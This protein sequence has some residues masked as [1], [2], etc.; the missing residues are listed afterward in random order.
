MGTSLP[1]IPPKPKASIQI[2]KQPQQAFPP[3]NQQASPPQNQ[4][5]EKILRWLLPNEHCIPTL[6]NHFLTVVLKLCSA[7]VKGFLVQQ[8][9]LIGYV[10]STEY[11]SVVTP[12]NQIFPWESLVRALELLIPMVPQIVFFLR[13][14]RLSDL[15]LPIEMDYS[16]VQFL[17]KFGVWT[18]VDRLQGFLTQYISEATSFGFGKPIASEVLHFILSNSDLSNQKEPINRFH[19]LQTLSL[20]THLLINTEVCA[21]LCQ[22]DS[23]HFLLPRLIADSASFEMS[24]HL[25]RLL[26]TTYLRTLEPFLQAQAYLEYSNDVSRLGAYRT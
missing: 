2:L 25:Y 10:E 5:P 12:T 16:F 21:L 7:L 3:Q 13:D 11:V 1:I 15:G 24:S 14:L 19:A 23:P 6:N 20:L 18:Q 8:G 17:V 22:R 26:A 4:Q 9:P